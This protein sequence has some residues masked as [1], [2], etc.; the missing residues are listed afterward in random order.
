MQARSAEA[1]LHARPATAY[2][3]T[4]QRRR[5]AFT[6]HAYRRYLRADC[7]GRDRWLL[8]DAPGCSRRPARV[9]A[10]RR[11]GRARAVRLAAHASSGGIRARIRGLW[12]HVH[13]RSVGCIS[14]TAFGL[15]P[16]TWPVR[17]LPWRAWRLSRFS[18]PGSAEQWAFSRTHQRALQRTASQ[19]AR[20]KASNIK[21]LAQSAAR[22]IIARRRRSFCADNNLRRTRAVAFYLACTISSLLVLVTGV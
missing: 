7:G 21:H 8:P 2:Q 22:R 20:G 9:V 17:R 3:F 1:H 12:R 6:R 5:R 18:R 14:W 19:L 10:D 4:Q 15:L 11:G 13:R 16:G